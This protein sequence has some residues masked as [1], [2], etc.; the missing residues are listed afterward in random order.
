MAATN[1]FEFDLGDVTRT[2]KAS[3]DDDDEITLDVGGVTFFVPRSVLRV[4]Y[5]FFDYLLST[6]DNVPPIDRDPTVF[7]IVLRYLRAIRDG[8]VPECLDALTELTAPERAKVVAEAD[9]YGLRRLRDY[10]L[11]GCR[12]TQAVINATDPYWTQDWATDG[13]MCYTFP[14]WPNYRFLFEPLRRDAR[15]HRW[16]FRFESRN[17]RVTVETRHGRKK[18]IELYSMSLPTNRPPRLA[19]RIGT[20]SLLSE[21][22]DLPLN[23]EYA[24]RPPH[25]WVHFFFPSSL[26]SIP[27]ALTI[28]S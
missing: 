2:D 7:H 13:S 16:A 26:T 23:S 12:N 1:G 10:V 27:P 28:G 18:L 5:N 24:A 20:G 8:R 4:T 3:V 14:R 11:C 19:G 22:E 17:F 9:Y 21:S 15:I 25:R 6:D